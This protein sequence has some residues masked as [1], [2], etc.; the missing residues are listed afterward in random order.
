MQ[1]KVAPKI[2][3]DMLTVNGENPSHGTLSEF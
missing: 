2:S 3:I 1:A